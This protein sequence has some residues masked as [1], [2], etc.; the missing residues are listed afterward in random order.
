MQ[1]SILSTYKRSNLSFVKGKGSYLITKKGKKYLDFASG[2]AVNSLG[3][4]N[5][6]L[7]KAL[8]NQSKKLWHVSNAFQISEQENLAKK[9]V[10]LTFADKVFFCN[11]G[12]ESVEC[13]IKIARA[14]HQ[15]KKK[16]KRFKIITIKGSFHGRTLATISASGQKKMTDGFEPLL[17]GFIQVKFGDHESIEKLIDNQTA[18]IMVEPILGEGGIKVVPNQ[19][20]EGLRDLCDKKK[21]L[22]IL[23]E[24]QCGI[25]RTGKFFYYQWSKMK[26]DILTTAKGIGGGFPI[27]AC[28]VSNEV[29]KG[30]KSGSH[31]S[32]FGGNPLA[33]SVANKVVDIISKKSFLFEVNK[34]SEFFFKK[35]EEIKNK[36]NKLITEIRGKGYLLG[37]K[38]R[39]N[40]N[41]L[42]E[43]LRTNGLLTI[44]ACEDVVRILPPLNVKK[45]EL[46]I[47]LEII[48]KTCQ[49]ISK[50]KY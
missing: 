32:T 45:K 2:I 24:I 13:A 40:N 11:S 50:K 12:A 47:A 29:S 23:D 9:L 49:E 5:L 35:L 37:I 22:L 4:C 46:K 41:I 36:Y 42:I 10:K 43:K 20:L 6:E 39:I 48:K 30:M 38:C 21:I 16:R 34:N 7:I 17:D 33:C 26:P 28:L 44:G 18:A 14:Y 15:I 31:G 19:C 25:G 1:S 27:G 3:H 8:N